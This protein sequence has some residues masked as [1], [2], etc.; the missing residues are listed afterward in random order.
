MKHEHAII[1][2][3]ECILDAAL[4]NEPI[5]RREGNT[6]QADLERKTIEAITAAITVLHTDPD[7]QDT[8]HARVKA[9]QAQL[10]S[11]LSKLEDFCLFNPKFNELSQEHRELLVEQRLCMSAYNDILLLRLKQFETE[12][13]V[14]DKAPV[15]DDDDMNDPLPTRTCN[16]DDENC[17]S[18]Q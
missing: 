18:C 9:E 10:S 11:R 15:S 12:S 13:A 7:A 2:M 17:E 14:A 1:L 8:P 5:N 16:L 4:N 6:D 3:Q